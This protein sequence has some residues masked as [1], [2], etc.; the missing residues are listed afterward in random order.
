MLLFVIEAD[1]HQRRDRSQRVVAGLVKELDHGGIDM[2]AVGRDFV[3]ARPGQVAALVPGV[4]GSGADI[5]GIE[6]EGIVGVKGLVTTA[7][8]A[9]KELSEEPGGMRNI[10]L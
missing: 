2:P 7:L 10:A 5:V 1:F 8:L 6:Q 9:K 3:S 4:P